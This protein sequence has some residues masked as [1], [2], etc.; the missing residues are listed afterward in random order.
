M[1]TRATKTIRISQGT[2]KDLQK[3][4]TLEDSFDSVIQGLLALQKKNRGV[5]TEK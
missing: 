4:G 1:Y 3:L 5:F 2:H